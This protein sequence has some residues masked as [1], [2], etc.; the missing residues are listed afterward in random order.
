MVSI[1][2]GRTPLFRT[3]FSDE[4]AWERLIVKMSE[5]SPNGFVANIKPINDRRY[6][7]AKPDM[8]VEEA[9]NSFLLIIADGT[10]MAD[11]EMPLLCV[12]PYPPG[13]Q[14][15]CIPAELWAVENNVSLA[16]MDFDEFALAVEA[17]GV[18]RGFHP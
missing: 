2:D 4:R 3:D 6:D 15:R 12:N 11:P 1:D 5:P 8:L 16:N 9:I 18:F 14:F 7:N 13:G 17:D 10:T